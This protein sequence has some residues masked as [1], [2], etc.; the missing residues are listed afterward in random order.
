MTDPGREGGAGDP[1]DGDKLPFTSHLEELRSRLIKSGL[2][3]IVGFFASYSVNERLYRVFTKPL[4]EA[5]PEGGHLG[6]FH[7]MEGFLTGL[8]ISVV[9]GIVLSLPVIFYQTWKFVAPGLYEDEKRYVWPFVFSATF[10]FLVG[11]SFAYFVVFPVAFKVLF[12]YAGEGAM[13]LPSM[14]S[15]LDFP[16]KLLLAFGLI[17]ELPVAVF[18]LSKMGLISHRTLSKN[19]SYSLVG[20]LIVAAVLTPTGDPFNQLLMAVPLYLLYEISIIV[21]RVFGPRPEPNGG[22][23]STEEQENREGGDGAK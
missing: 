15:A 7:P 18:F 1:E 17:F 21:A 13:A 10:F 4:R 22:T 12:G 8:K 2:A 9:A 20:I 6:M 11:A 5:L 3:V 23:E 16:L 14:E 19:R